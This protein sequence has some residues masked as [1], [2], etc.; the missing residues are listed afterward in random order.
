MRGMKRVRYGDEAVMIGDEFGELLLE[1]AAALARNNT[2]EPL[3]FNAVNSEGQ[4]SASFLLGP[5]SQLTVLE[6]R[7]DL[8]EPDN[9]EAEAV[10]RG[11]L[12]ELSFP[13][14]HPV[15]NDRS[16]PEADV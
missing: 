8:P 5:A 10:M 3:H 2:A 15:E 14:P 7:S 6:T 11:R 9:S 16:S 4:V 12:K 1:Y 13:V